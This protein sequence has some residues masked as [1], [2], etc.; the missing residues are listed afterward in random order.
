MTA[1][2][3]DVDADPAL[4]AGVEG[5]AASDDVLSIRERRLVVEA[6][7]EGAVLADWV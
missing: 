5:F 4:G 6:S 1:S 3:A 7:I 2:N